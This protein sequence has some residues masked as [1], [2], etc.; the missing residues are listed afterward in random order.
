M[1]NNQKENSLKDK[2]AKGL[3]WGGLSN[4]V[5]QLLNMII[6][7]FLARILS[8]DDYGMVGM[9][10]I[11]TL[12]AGVLQESGFTAALVNKK[13]IEHTDYNAVFWFTTLMGICMYSI[14]FACAPLIAAFYNKPEL[15]SLA[16]FLFISIFVSSTSITHYAYLFK[17]LMVKQRAIAQ[18]TALVL[19][20]TI[21]IILALNDFA[22]WGIAIQSV[23]YTIVST[24]VCW[25]FSGWR[26]TLTINFKPLKGMFAFSWRLLVTNIFVQLNNNIF[27]VL[28]GRFF[29]VAD[30]GHYTQANKWNN[31]GYSLIT[32]MVNGVAQPVLVQ[33]GDNNERKLIVFRKMLRFT[34]FISFP[35]MLGL[36][37]V[38][39]EF[40]VITVKEK[41][42]PCVQYLQILCFSG[43]FF[44][45]QALYSSLIISKG[46]SKVQLW[47]TISQC[48]LLLVLML[49]VCKHGILVMIICSVC[50]NVCWLAIW[51]YFVKK[52]I[53]LSNLC[54]IT[55]VCPFIFA[56]AFTMIVT[57]FLTIG[58]NNIY[59]LFLAKVSIAAATYI[60]IMWISNATIFKESINYLI[61]QKK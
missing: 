7:I 56:A 20:G 45:I 61:K 8:P 24:S 47:T 28:L 41:W 40:I 22:Y 54:A 15:T 36:A 6:G 27:S 38:A 44:P 35:L 26:P 50:L 51:Q 2:T 1:R 17:N 30:V 48:T 3:F 19:S 10:T 39:P 18:I 46:N 11:F 42:L 12:I 49:T 52:A 21:G 5:Q 43:A 55:D 14:L 32:G 34:A 29:G 53:G 60:L 13:D 31:M 9:L 16:R 37:L 57:H 25:F 23:S 58:L 4:G 59:I 33:V